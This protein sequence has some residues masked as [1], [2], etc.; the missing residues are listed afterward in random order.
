MTDVEGLFEARQFQAVVTHLQGHA[1]T[2]REA[3]LLGISL[4]RVGRLEDAEVSLTRASVQG[5]PEGQVELG[6]VLRLLGR[7]DEAAR[8]LETISSDLTGEL[9]LRCLRWWGVSEFQLGHTEDGLRRLERAWHGYLALGDGE[10]SARVTLSLAE[11]YRL[12]GND[13]RAKTL[14]T[15]AL[16]ALPKDLY[17]GPHVEALKLLLEIHLARGEFN[18]A[19][20]VLT[21]A[22][23]LL[24][25]VKSPRLTALLLTSEAELLRLTGEG[26]AYGWVLEELGV[27][28]EA[29]ADSDLRLWTLSRLAEHHSL[30][31]RHGKAVD[32]LLRYGTMPEAWPAELVATNGVIQRRRGDLL[33]AQVSLSQAAGMFR[34]AGRVPDLC[35]VQLHY[36]AACLRSGGEEVGRTVLPALTEAITQLLRL[37]QLTEFKPDFEELS[38]LLHYALLEPDTAPLMEPLLDHLAH[39]AGSARLPEDGAIQ[40]TVKTLGQMVVFKDGA[41]V[42]FTRKGCVP[43]LV[44][45]ALHPDRTRAQMQLDL[46]PDKDGVTG[47]SYVRQCLKELRDK[48]GHELVT[49]QGPHHAPAYRLGRLVNVDLDLTQLQEAVDGKETARALALYRGAFLPEADPSE[50]VETQREALLLALTYEL[51]AQMAQARSDGEYRR[52]VLLANQYLRVDP[53]AREVM[54][55]RVAAARLVAS[56]QEIARYTAELNRHLYN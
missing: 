30:H 6:N 22:K 31:G 12:I 14:L 5:D 43:L 53:Y 40:L 26:T 4:I 17:P 1:R 54:E 20:E 8:H 18:E 21:E 37:R 48:L 27:L 49:Y 7:F 25:G 56:P 24:P 28:A 23:R 3:T 19:R 44:Y 15:E 13:K 16:Y 51:R 52:V 46:W 34:A 2:A 36:A 42:P 35:R 47:S 55:E 32:V 41:E 10:L 39:L 50:W 45:L 29:L 9:H 11:M 33:A 38:E